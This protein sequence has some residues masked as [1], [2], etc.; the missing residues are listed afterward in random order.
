MVRNMYLQ[1]V[2]ATLF[3]LTSFHPLAAEDVIQ[4]PDQSAISDKTTAAQVKELEQIF[5]ETFN[6]IMDVKRTI[7][8]AVLITKKYGKGLKNKDIVV[9]NLL[10]AAGAFDTFIQVKTRPI[11][12][13]YQQK[14]DTIPANAYAEIYSIHDALLQHI[15][16]F[17]EALD[18]YI[19]SNF[20]E[21]F[22]YQFLISKDAFLIDEQI[23]AEA[24]MKHCKEVTEKIKKT[25]KN[26]DQ[27]GLT[28]WIRLHA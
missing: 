14:P 16:R 4:L 3:F 22:E 21:S 20:K 17:L 19:Q 13:Y 9:K 26:S 15:A 8:H 28:R 27:I 18:T 23:S 10:E 24:V 12:H 5:E 1:N 25:H 7:S 2:F 6:N 11:R